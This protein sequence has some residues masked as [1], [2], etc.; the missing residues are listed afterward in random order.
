MKLGRPR[1]GISFYQSLKRAYSKR[2]SSLPLVYVACPELG[3][4]LPV[5]G[6]SNLEGPSVPQE[7]VVLTTTIPE[8]SHKLE[9]PTPATS[10]PSS[11]QKHQIKAHHHAPPIDLYA[12]I[13]LKVSG[14][15]P[16]RVCFASLRS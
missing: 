7:I 2:I 1:S 3:G 11:P 14:A 6:L 15:F 5:L 10:T 13:H 12:G 9:R 16:C 8:S 4:R